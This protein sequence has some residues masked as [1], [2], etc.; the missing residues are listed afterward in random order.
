[1]QGKAPQMSSALTSGIF[2]AGANHIATRATT[3]VEAIQKGL[4]ILKK[5]GMMSLCIYSGGD[6]GFEEKE[7]ILDYLRETSGAG[8]YGNRQMR[9]ITGQQPSNP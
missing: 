2:Q 1:M 5:G 8:V 7:R 3:S 9:T 4:K 6:T